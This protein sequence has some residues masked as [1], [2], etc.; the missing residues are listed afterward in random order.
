MAMSGPVGLH[1]PRAAG[2][3]ADL[4]VESVLLEDARAHADVQQ[5]EGE[6]A[7]HRLAEA[8]DLGAGSLCE[9]GRQRATERVREQAPQHDRQRPGRSIAD[10]V[11]RN[12]S[13][14]PRSEHWPSV[15]DVSI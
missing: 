2:E 15:A 12:F 10:M 8:H 3:C 1:Q 14:T 13:R 11:H 9:E 4:E 5:G 6:R 7:G